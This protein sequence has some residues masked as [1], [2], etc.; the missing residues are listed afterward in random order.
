MSYGLVLQRLKEAEGGRKIFFHNCLIW[1]K[2]V[3]SNSQ[4][5]I[6]NEFSMC[7]PKAVLPCLKRIMDWIKGLFCSIKAYK[8]SPTLLR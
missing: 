5:K 7:R 1:G 8:K 6:T 2:N 4:V 3:Q